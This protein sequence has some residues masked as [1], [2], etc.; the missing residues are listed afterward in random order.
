VRF[1][2]PAWGNAISVE[3][4]TALP[5]APEFV[6]AAVR[7]R[8]RAVT[9]GSDTLKNI[10]IDAAWSLLLALVVPRLPYMNRITGSDLSRTLKGSS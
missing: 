7:H 5:S 1:P 4:R 2:K 3:D 6:V 8:I 9:R 10:T